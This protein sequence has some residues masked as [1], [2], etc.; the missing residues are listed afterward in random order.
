[1]ESYLVILQSTVRRPPEDGLKSGTETC[2]GK[3]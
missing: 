1:M 3:F 2:I